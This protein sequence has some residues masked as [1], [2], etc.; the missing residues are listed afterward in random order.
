[1]PDTGFQS[2]SLALSY[3][4]VLPPERSSEKQGKCEP[5]QSEKASSENKT[6]AFK[7]E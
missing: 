7:N 1:M 6:W 5:K 2:K 4:T 3:H